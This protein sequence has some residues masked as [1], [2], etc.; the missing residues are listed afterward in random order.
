MNRTSGAFLVPARSSSPS[1]SIQ[2]PGHAVAL[3]LQLP[4]FL[5]QHVVFRYGLPKD[6][7]ESVH[8]SSPLM[9]QDEYRPIPSPPLIVYGCACVVGLGS[10]FGLQV[11]DQSRS[12]F[13]AKVFEAGSIVAGEQLSNVCLVIVCFSA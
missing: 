12:I 10:Q 1:P 7:S 5:F 11:G 9:R 8:G 6:S 4:D 2:T 13:S 3:F